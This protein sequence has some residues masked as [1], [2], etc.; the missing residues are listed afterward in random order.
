[1]KS[2][3]FFRCS[4]H[5][6]ICLLS[7]THFYLTDPGVL[8]WQYQNNNHVC[9]ASDANRRWQSERLQKDDE[10]TSFFLSGCNE[11]WLFHFIRF[12][13]SFLEPLGSACRSECQ[14][15]QLKRRIRGEKT[16]MNNEENASLIKA[17]GHSLWDVR[18]G[19]GREGGG[20]R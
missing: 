4:S 13:I 5:H 2:T 16:Y 12:G 3:A 7:T 15:G 14:L 18:T 17:L 6:N 1:M 9:S 20:R 19:K 11:N 8:K 10:T